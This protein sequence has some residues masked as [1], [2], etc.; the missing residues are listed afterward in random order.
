[1]WYVIH[2]MAG[3]EQKCMQQCQECIDASAYRDMFIPRYITKKHF[4]KAWHE[5]IKPLF[6]GYLFVD[7]DEIEPIILGLKQFRQYTKLLRDGEMISPIKKDEQEFLWLMMDKDYVVQYS[8]GFLIGDEVY[9][10][11]GPLK[12]TQGWIRTVDRHRRIA[13]MEIPIFGRQ[14]LIEVGL[15]TIA[16]VEEKELKQMISG[17]IHRQKDEENVENQVKVKS[18]VFEGI[19]G[20]FL[21]ADPTRDEWTVEIE[22]FGAETKVTFRREELEM[23]L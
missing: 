16:R 17:A 22:L 13:K 6:P 15:G 11:S 1:M 23:F 14:T 8:E 18:G 9:I 20:R 3:L 10:T 2:T 21:C 7:T 4:K 5:V 12:R 19:K